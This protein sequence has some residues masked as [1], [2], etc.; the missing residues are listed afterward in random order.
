[1][2]PY[3]QTNIKELEKV[4]RQAATCLIT[5]G[6]PFLQPV[7]S[8]ILYLPQVYE[9]IDLTLRVKS[10]LYHHFPLRLAVIPCNNGDLYFYSSRTPNKHCSLAID[11]S[12][13]LTDMRIRKQRHRA[14]R[15]SWRDW[16]RLGTGHNNYIL[17]TD[18]N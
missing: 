4:R 17:M 6:A 12:P 9:A 8:F 2:D 7:C 5:G 16:R 14:I 15:A 18:D 1:M 11:R 3:T 13:R 10:F